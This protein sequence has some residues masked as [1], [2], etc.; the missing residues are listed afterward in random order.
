MTIQELL[1][2]RRARR[3]EL[4]R[5]LDAILDGPLGDGRDL[6]DEERSA[7]N[8]KR[9]EIRRLDNEIT[10]LERLAAEDSTSGE[11]AGDDAGDGDEQVADANARAAARLDSGRGT[12]VQVRSE[13]LTYERH[14]LR[15]SY[16]ADRYNAERN[17]DQDAAARLS[18][19][20]AEVRVELP[21]IER[22]LNVAAPLPN[23]EG[24]FESRDLSSDTATEGAEFVP[25]LWM[26]QEFIEV[27]R[28]GRV[29]ADLCN[30]RPLPAGTDSIN[31]PKLSTGTAVASQDGDNAAVAET[32]AATT[33]V[34]APVRTIAGQQDVSVQLLEQSPL[35]FDEVIFADLAADYAIK[36]DGQVIEG[37]GVNGQI[38]GL[39]TVSGT[40][41][42][43]YTDA[44]PTGLELYPKVG[45]AVQRVVSNGK[46]PA[47]AVVMHPRRWYW[48][49]TQG[50]G[51]SR[52]LVVPNAHGPQNA[53]GVL[54]G[55][56]E[57]MVGT[58]LGLPVYIDANVPT[59]LGTN[60]D[61]IIAARFSDAW[62]FEGAVRTRVLPGPGSSTLTTRLQLYRYAAFT[63]ARLP[64]RISKI[65]GT[66]LIAPTF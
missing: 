54:T 10:D 21:R 46:M 34:A 3:G 24:S 35:A 12:A 30:V 53:V 18:C 14:N 20:R 2:R 48:L 7:F 45:D 23:G 33:S 61:A 57:G 50:D 41:A 15:R 66:G 65:T 52:P 40:G 17:G 47:T 1:E 59:D 26:M 9:A 19:H 32:D 37:T 60:E 42:V 58:I 51:S 43:T 44:T 36:L 38:E 55:S 56:G 64:A 29:T 5:E 28:S 31:L 6:D 63:A 27:A 25:P 49:A 4:R 8:D 22:G 11:N 39:L 13:P 62:L 16:F